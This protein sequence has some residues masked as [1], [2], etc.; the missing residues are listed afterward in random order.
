MNGLPASAVFA[1]NA[2]R[3]KKVCSLSAAVAAGTAKNQRLIHAA[4][5]F[6]SVWNFLQ[7]DVHATCYMAT[8]KFTGTA[9]IDDGHYSFCLLLVLQNPDRKISPCVLMQK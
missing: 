4:K 7:R 5:I 2:M 6:Q 9:Y 3:L 8:G 1:A